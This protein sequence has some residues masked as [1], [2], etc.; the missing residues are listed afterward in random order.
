[1]RAWVVEVVERGPHRTGDQGGELVGE[2]G[3][4]RSVTTVD[5][6]HGGPVESRDQRGEVGQERVAG[7]DASSSPPRRRHCSSIQPLAVPS[8]P[9]VSWRRRPR[10]SWVSRNAWL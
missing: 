1:M 10:V 2:D 8:Q 5:G 6:H 3:L 7:Y 4:A 9:A